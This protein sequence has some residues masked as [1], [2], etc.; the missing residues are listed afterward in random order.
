MIQE[1]NLI[2][3]KRLQD[4]IEYLGRFRA[5]IA[6][7]DIDAAIGFDHASLVGEVNQKFD[8]RFDEF[9]SLSY[10]AS[11][12]DLLGKIPAMVCCNKLI[13][14]FYEVLM[15]IPYKYGRENVGES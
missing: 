14:K 9:K 11:T 13:I 1:Q 7:E 2:N 15:A 10:A 5:F 6:S 12:P 4:I 8:I 3:I